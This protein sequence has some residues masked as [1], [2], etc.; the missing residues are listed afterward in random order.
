MKNAPT[1]SVD[2]QHLNHIN[3]D[4]LLQILFVNRSHVHVS[5]NLSKLFKMLI[6]SRNIVTFQTHLVN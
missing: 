2:Q 5:V 1:L 6:K 4:V 3:I